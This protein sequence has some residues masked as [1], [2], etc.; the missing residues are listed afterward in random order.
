MPYKQWQAQYQTGEKAMLPF[1]VHAHRRT[2][3][4]RRAPRVYP[5]PP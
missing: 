1:R 2:E 4:T 3:L 5:P